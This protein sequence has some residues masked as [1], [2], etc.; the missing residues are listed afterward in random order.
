ML[1]QIVKS[2]PSQDPTSLPTHLHDSDFHLYPLAK[3]TFPIQNDFPPTSIAFIGLPSQV[4]PF[5]LCEDQAVAA[6]H[7][8]A[9]AGD[10][11][12]QAEKGRILERNDALTK[13]AGDDKRALARA[14]HRL[15]G[16]QAYTLRRELLSF[17]GWSKWGV[18][19]WM[20]EAYLQKE[21]LREQWK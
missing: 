13:K 4:V 12:V 9:H 1:P 18:E 14:W 2:F 15:P 17:A 20:E 11:D 5:P 21:T 10:L 6:F 8:F 19:E 16:E 3:Q 7:S